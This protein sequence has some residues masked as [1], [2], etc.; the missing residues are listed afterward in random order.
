MPKYWQPVANR[1]G[2]DLGL[3]TAGDAGGPF[4]PPF[5]IDAIIF[6][7]CD[8][9]LNGEEAMTTTE[10][11][12]AL[13]PVEALTRRESQMLVFLAEGYSRQEIATRLTL[14]LASVKF[15]VQHLYGKLGV[16]SKRQAL[17]RAQAL[18]LLANPQPAAPADQ[19]PPANGGPG[20]NLPLQLTNFIGRAQ[21]LA[22]VRR[23]LGGTRL[24]TLT[25]PGGT[26]K[27]RLALQVAAECLGDFA[28][29]AH[30]VWL[31][32]LA[33]I[34]EP[35]LIALALAQALAVRTETAGSFEAALVGFASRD[36][37]ARIIAHLRDKKLLLILDNCEHLVGAAAQLAELLLRSAPGLRILATSREALGVPGEI[38][39]PVPSLV[40]PDFGPL[41]ALA[42]VAQSEAVQ[43]F[44]ERAQAVRPDFALTVENVSAVT[45]ICQRLDGMPLAIELAAARTR[46]LAVE[47][48]A[49]LLDDRFGLLTGG[50]RSAP[51]RQQT[52][53][54]AIDWSY[55][56][57]TDPERALLPR[58]SMFAGGWTLEAAEHV[59]GPDV[60][61][62][63]TEL[64][65]KSLVLSEQRPGQPARFRMLETI[66]Q[67]AQEKLAGEHE[68]VR[69]RHLAFYLAL[70]E[71]AQPELRH[72][73]QV[74]WL[75]RLEQETDNF[76]AALAWALKTEDAQSALRLSG[77]FFEYWKIRSYEV[78]GR[79]WLLAALGLPGSRG[80]LAH[81]A[82]RAR[83]LLGAGWC[84]SYLAGYASPAA[85]AP[86][87][88][89]E[90]LSLFRELDDRA[91]MATALLF[92]GLLAAY[93]NTPA[94]AL[95]LLNEALELWTAVDDKTGIGQCL[96]A[97]G[98]AAHKAGNGAKAGEYHQR[99]LLIL[100]DQGDRRSQMKSLYS[101]AI[102]S[103]LEGDGAGARARFAE[104]LVGYAELGYLPGTYMTL[105]NLFGIAAAQGH[106]AQA[107]VIALDIQK[108]DWD[109][110]LASGH[111][112]LGQV[113]YWQGDLAEARAHFETGLM[114]FRK[115]HDQ[116][117][118]VW[119][120][121]WLGYVAYRAGNL[122]EA[123]ALIEQSLAS[124]KPGDGW[125]ELAFA[126]LARGDTARAQGQPVAAAECYARS[127]RSVVENNS[128]PDVA[129]R[130]EGFAK[131]AAL[132]QL[133]QCA[134]RLFGAAEAL[135]ERI[136]TPIPPVERADYDGSVVLARSQFDQAAF[137]AAWAEGRVL[138]WMQA[139]AYALESTTT[140]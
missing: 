110:A 18:G 28:A 73:G 24:L 68:A 118:M 94:S 95:A 79:P 70:A 39:F 55:A 132:A 120:P 91:G 106:Y 76:R 54:A 93:S 38:S 53:R 124:Q 99:S 10:G 74:I 116:N 129:A 36:A 63:L 29:F 83:A 82:W 90:S 78:E 3:G 35:P 26:G 105:S 107:R 139:A 102:G 122:D 134:V 43:L 100:R 117:W 42:T 75:K 23:R 108:L 13:P 72:H 87:E 85:S 81:S 32:E 69:G 66:R 88:L 45:E 30:G 101:L 140:A 11:D 80:P 98:E 33:P 71:L 136:G 20:H 64:V 97:L 58:L 31:V 37:V 111:M 119:A 96:N 126:L 57:L 4:R 2:W 61:D 137:G 6:A 123:Q 112:R 17:D 65:G 14:G 125:S 86:P 7:R 48:I 49:A 47:Q 46:A 113:D 128:Q 5:R 77:A 56:L 62:G 27:T 84:L 21:Q 89:E 22:E 92:L 44:T 121:T 131:L 15:H 67:Y 114:M 40:V 50:N 8:R 16:N 59:G 115:L 109:K 51:P 127:L 103:W 135:R 133:T 41:P 138:S 19:P 130:L 1:K 104:N 52:L 60:R 12:S 25:G 34:S 9:Q